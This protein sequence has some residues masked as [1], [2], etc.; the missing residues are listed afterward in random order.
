MYAFVV[1][2][3]EEPSG[4]V[5]KVAH[6][7][8]ILGE[9][10]LNIEEE[11]YLRCQGMG[12]TGV[13]FGVPPLLSHLPTSFAPPAALNSRHC[14]WELLVLPSNLICSIIPSLP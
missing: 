7:P 12:L 10:Y 3:S 11:A 6:R 8:D 14:P 5:I 9:M 2:G 4:L 13:P 1:P